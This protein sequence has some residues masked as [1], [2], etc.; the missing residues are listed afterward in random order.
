[1]GCSAMDRKKAVLVIGLGRIGLPQA[2]VLADQGF[3]VYGYARNAAMLDTLSEHKVPFVEADLQDLLRKHYGKNFIP[4]KTWEQ[5]LEILPKIDGIFFSIGTKT[6]SNKDIEQELILDLS[7]YYALF[8]QIF[9]AKASLKKPITLIIRTTVP[10]GTT[11]QFKQYLEKKYTYKESKDF[12]LGFV[13]ERIIEGAAIKELQRLPRIIGTYSDEGFAAIQA[14]VTQRGREVI[15]VANP[16]TAEFCK[17]TDNSYRSTLFAYVNEL[18]M[19]ANR[20]NINIS[21]VIYAANQHYHRNHLPQP[22]FVSGYCLSKDPYIFE[23]DFLKHNPQRDFHSLWYYAR[24]TN[25]YFMQFVVQ[26]IV[27][28]VSGRPNAC[29]AILGL[30]F[31]ANVDDFRLAHAF[32]IIDLLIAEHITNFKVYD[33]KLNKNEYTRLPEKY[34]PYVQEATASLSPKILTNVTVVVLL[35][36]HQRLKNSNNSEKLAKLLANTQQPCYVFDP[37]QLWTEAAEIK[38]IQY[39][40]LEGDMA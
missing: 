11:D 9:A 15:R 28:F 7:G 10:L 30:S 31:K 16:L 6:V 25:D 20:L 1:M 22:G 37:Y 14:L 26:K 24:R 32:T 35:N 21:E 40:N 17:L 2:L 39:A 34:L 23:L 3:Q 5:T 36:P 38:H 29:V 18:A 8:D 12:F 13:P 33:P 27:N 4:F 19:Y